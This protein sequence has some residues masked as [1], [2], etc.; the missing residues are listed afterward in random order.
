MFFIKWTI[1]S[2]Y[3]EDTWMVTGMMILYFII[4]HDG[5]LFFERSKSGRGRV[6]CGKYKT[7]IFKDGCQKY[8]QIN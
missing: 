7:K 3:Y 6:T 8:K 1:Y 5:T 4:L 2:Q